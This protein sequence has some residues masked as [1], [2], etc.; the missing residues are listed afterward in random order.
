[1][2]K[3]NKSSLPLLTILLTATV[4]FASFGMARAE[5]KNINVPK[6]YPTLDAA[7]AHASVG[8]LILLSKTMLSAYSADLPVEDQALFFLRDVFQIDMAKYSASQ[9]I[10]VFPPDFVSPTTSTLI[11]YRLESLTTNFEAVFT[12]NNAKYETCYIQRINGTITYTQQSWTVGL[13]SSNSTEIKDFKVL[14]SP[15]QAQLGMNIRGDYAYPY[16]RVDLYLDK[17]YPGEVSSIA[18]GIWADTGDVIY[19]QELSYGAGAP[20]TPSPSPSTSPTITPAF[21]P[22]PTENVTLTPQPILSFEPTSIGN[23]ISQNNNVLF[24]AGVATTVMATGALAI[25]LTLKL[26]WKRQ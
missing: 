12:F 7:K 5:A 19:C 2:T 20:Q 14:N 18:V 10:Q 26:K 24:W 1:M 16:W 8:D 21:T 22:T 3:H 25:L 13:D 15:V 9:K 17:V 23:S 11:G 4:I 6:D